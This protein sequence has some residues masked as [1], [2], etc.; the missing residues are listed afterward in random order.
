MQIRGEYNTLS[1]MID[2]CDSTSWMKIE[3]ET[4]NVSTDDADDDDKS[5][6]FKQLSG[7]SKKIRF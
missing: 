6:Y 4:L 2:D 1:V 3:K 5:T 7:I